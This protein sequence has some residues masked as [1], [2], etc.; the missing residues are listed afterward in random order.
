MRLRVKKIRKFVTTA[1]II[2]HVVSVISTI[3]SMAV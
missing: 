1:K 3:L 2:L